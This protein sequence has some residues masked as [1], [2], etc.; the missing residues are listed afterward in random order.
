M[1]PEARRALVMAPFPTTR[2]IPGK[3]WGGVNLG[4]AGAVPETG[5]R[6]WTLTPADESYL[7]YGKLD[8]DVDQPEGTD[9]V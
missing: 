1:T 2:R 7:R 4:N 5:H 6:P 3:S 9:I 8:T